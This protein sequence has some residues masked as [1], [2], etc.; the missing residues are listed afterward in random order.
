[1]LEAHNG[2]KTLQV[3]LPNE[4]REEFFYKDYILDRH[5]FERIIRD[6]RV[7][8]TAGPGGSRKKKVLEEF[9]NLDIEFDDRNAVELFEALDLDCNG[10]LEI[11]ELEQGLKN[12]VT[13]VS[14]LQILKLR[15][16]IVKVNEKLM[17]SAHGT[18]STT[19]FSSDAG[20]GSDMGVPAPV[21]TP[22]KES[23][24]RL[25]KVTSDVDRLQNSIDT[26]RKTLTELMDLFLEQ[27]AIPGEP[28][29]SDDD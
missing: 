5:H 8:D 21:W 15:A 27:Q 12:L 13:D 3:I 11:S 25:D 20:V 29:E 26:T 17:G 9:R 10:H 28:V 22:T 2:A 24:E 18:S 4:K 23:W 7:I 14:Q 6:Q 1:M 19:K 16:T